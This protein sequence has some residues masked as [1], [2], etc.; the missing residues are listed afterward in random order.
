MRAAWRPDR[1]D[2]PVA[3]IDESH[4]SPRGDVRRLVRRSRAGARTR[5][6]GPVVGRRVIRGV[7]P[8]ASTPTSADEVES[9]GEQRAVRPERRPRSAAAEGRA[10]RQA[11]PRARRTCSS[12]CW[13]PNS[14]DAGVRGH[15]LAAPQLTTD[16]MLDSAG[17]TRGRRSCARHAMRDELQRAT[18][19]AGSASRRTRAVATVTST[20]RVAKRCRR[21]STAAILGTMR[22]AVNEADR[23]GGPRAVTQSMECRS[24]AAWSAVRDASPCGA[25]A[26]ERIRIRG[27]T[28]PCWCATLERECADGAPEDRQPRRSRPRAVGG[29]TRCRQPCRPRCSK[30]SAGCRPARCSEMVHGHGRTAG[31]RG[32]CAHPRAALNILRRAGACRLERELPRPQSRFIDR[33]R[34][35]MSRMPVPEKPALEGLEAK[36]T[37]RWESDGTYRFDRSRPRDEVYAID[38][39]PP[40]VS[41]SLHVGHV[42]SYTH[43]DIIARFQRMRGKEVFYPMGWD[44]NGLP[45]E[46]RVQNYFGV[47]CDPSLPY[48]PA[49]TPPEKPDKHA[50][51]RCRGRTSS[52]CARKLTRRGREGL[53]APVAVPGPLGGLVDDLRHHRQARAAR[54]AADVPAAARA[55]PR[56]SARGADAVGRGL[57]DRGRPGRA[58]RPRAARARTTASASHGPSAFRFATPDAPTPSRSRRRARS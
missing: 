28:I 40:T 55:R 39:P 24:A 9:A 49:F 30:R 1:S 47:R 51:L 6:S 20:P 34:A 15:P 58:R 29:R 35:T 26:V 43:T 25:D 46:R 52:S 44:D 2:V 18:R 37:A 8:A 22:G 19:H 38:T 57:Q 31:A 56:V 32:D 12:R 53:R 50:D 41:G 27:V 14:R 17:G 10:T 23:R 54:V 33:S 45:T 4:G 48:D 5:P 11:S 42:F 21:R 36:W 13:R 7:G 3:R 16:E